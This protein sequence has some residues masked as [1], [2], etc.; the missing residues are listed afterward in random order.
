MT[1]AFYP[2][3]S[4]LGPNS[5]ESKG[6]VLNLWI[7][8]GEGGRA[9][10]RFQVWRA[11]LEFWGITLMGSTDVWRGALDLLLLC[12]ATSAISQAHHK[13]SHPSSL[14]PKPGGKGSWDSSFLYLLP[15]HRENSSTPQTQNQ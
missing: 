15:Q 3:L 1:F 13:P 11:C 10:L 4:F 7:P 8:G 12:V 9:G 5:L 6:H 2:D 14:S